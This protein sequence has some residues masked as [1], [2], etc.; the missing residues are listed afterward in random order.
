MPH[1]DTAAATTT[2]SDELLIGIDAIAGF[3]ELNR[4]T[5]SRL[6]RDGLPCVRLGLPLMSTRKLVVAWVEQKALEGKRG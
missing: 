5:V 3:L 1:D 6:I 4:K 2:P